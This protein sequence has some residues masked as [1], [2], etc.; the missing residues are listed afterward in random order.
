M[1]E[2][3]PISRIKKAIFGVRYH[4]VLMIFLAT[5]LNYADRALI[6][7]V[8]APIQA[9]FSIDSIQMGFIFS[10]FSWPYVAAQIPGG[11]LLDRF[12]VKRVY[13]ASIFFWSL[14]SM[15]QGWSGIF[16]AKGALFILF[17]LRFLTGL[18]EAPAFPGN[19]RLVAAW[20]PTAERG[21]ASAIFNSAQ[22]F[23]PVLML[24][25]ASWIA[26]KWGWQT[27]FFLMGG[28]GFPFVL[29][30]LRA[31]YCPKDHPRLTDKERTHLVAGGALME[32]GGL[33]R[34]ERAPGA[35][36]FYIM[37]LLSNRMLL[38]IY[39][40]Q[41]CTNALTYFFLTWFPIYLVKQH[42]LTIMQ[43]GFVASLPALC[44]F[45][46]GISGGM[47][48]DFMMRK[49]GSLSLARKVPIM[50]GMFLSMVIM[51]CNYVDSPALVILFMC[52]SF[53]GKGV[54]A[55]GWAVIADTAPKEIGGLS[56]GVFN[57][58]SGIGGI[59]TPIVIGY[60]VEGTG[61]F[62]YALVFVAMNALMVIVS[63][64]FLVGEI[65]RVVLKPAPAY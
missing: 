47:F 49:T 52:L 33:K 61:S 56:G 19:A 1:L 48:S 25:I 57:C 9:E 4:M 23:S 62:D 43:A 29:L 64:L 38:G 7:I 39:L 59:T 50:A 65:K 35:T 20:F 41:F 51:A 24:P 37:Q 11:W 27:A 3:M 45:A 32:M 14:F 15:A 22:Y 10:A 18:A 28:I 21:Q 63:Y 12:G 60:L 6:S 40:A 34:I 13:A 26:E 16:G 44:G 8:G 46:G 17:G 30:W 42:G 54:G 53:F 58:I 55:L 5:T 2:S 31:V 36:W